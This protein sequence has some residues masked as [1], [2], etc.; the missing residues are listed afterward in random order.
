MGTE[1]GKWDPC[2]PGELRQ[3]PCG[4]DQSDPEPPAWGSAMG[5]VVGQGHG[6][7]ST[8]TWLGK[9]AGILLNTGSQIYTHSRIKARG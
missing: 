3:S 5:V 2:S 8:L 9:A 6:V 4:P 7:L 1:G